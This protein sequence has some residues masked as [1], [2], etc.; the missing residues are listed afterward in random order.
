ML[1]GVDCRKN[2][3]LSS[4]PIF[5]ICL[6]SMPEVVFTKANKIKFDALFVLKTVLQNVWIAELAGIG[7]DLFP[8]SIVPNGSTNQFDNN[9][10]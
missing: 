4:S 10:Q 6:T 2:R 3:I 5:S 9:R 7:K 8:Y 1:S